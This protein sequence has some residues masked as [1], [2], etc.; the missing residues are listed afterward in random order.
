M[1]VSRVIKSERILAPVSWRLSLCVLD[2]SDIS[3]TKTV[4]IRFLSAFY[5]EL[6]I[7]NIYWNF[8]IF[9]TFLSNTRI[10]GCFHSPHFSSCIE[11]GGSIWDLSTL[12]HTYIQNFL[13]RPTPT[14]C[15]NVPS[16]LALFS[17]P[18]WN[19]GKVLWEGNILWTFHMEQHKDRGGC[20]QLWY[21]LTILIGAHVYTD[22][23]NI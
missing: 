21:C 2:I 13:E 3:V 8:P 10:K 16:P 19:I 9:Y 7:N 15:D 17:L 22:Y 23:E 14:L 20:N 1:S 4:P 11:L 6:S 12:F 18:K 5:L